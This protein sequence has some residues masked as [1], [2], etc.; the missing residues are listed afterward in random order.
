LGI[1][2]RTEL[3]VRVKVNREKWKMGE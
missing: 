1:Q 3:L 2:N